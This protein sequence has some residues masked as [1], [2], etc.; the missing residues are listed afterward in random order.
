LISVEIPTLG[1][2]TLQAA[3]ESVRRQTLQDY[4]VLVL[5]S[6]PGFSASDV[7][8]S[9]G[10]RVIRARCGLLRARYELHAASRGDHALLL[11]ATRLLRRDALEILRGTR[12]EMVVLAER[13]ARTGPLSGAIDLDRRLAVE[14][15]LV[16]R[17]AID[18]YVL[19]RYFS[20]RLLSRA[21]D[22]VRAELGGD[23]D[24]IVGE[25]HR[26]IFLEARRISGSIGI[27]EDPLIL[28]VGD[29]GVRGILRK[30]I[31]YGRS[32]AVAAGHYAE[33]GRRR[34]RSARGVGA[35]E[36]AGLYLL[37]AV[38]LAGHSIGYLAGIVGGGGSV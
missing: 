20:S 38:Q 16:D 24:R 33:I 22:A 3:L 34:P 6:S 18:A 28:H 36:L 14:S 35:G 25:D 12:W 17:D 11:D 31:R 19:P 32:A 30:Q 7:A 13:E 29:G 10:A 26:M 8:R 9:Y 15:A 37:Y 21:M 27:V 4:E 1:E 2:P 5:D 23:F